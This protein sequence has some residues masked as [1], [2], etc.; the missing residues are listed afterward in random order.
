MRHSLGVVHRDLKPSNILLTK[1]DVP[2]ISDFGLAKL[3]GEQDDSASVTHL[4]TILGTPSYMA[5]EQTT[6]E[7]EEIGRAVDIYA[8][9]MILYELLAGRRPFQAGTVMEMMMQIRERRPD[10]P[11]RWQPGLPPS[12]TRSACAAWRSC[13]GTAT[14]RPESWPTPWNGS[15]RRPRVRAPGFW[16]RAWGLLPFKR[17]EGRANRQRV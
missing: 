5:P 17:T 14:R 4:G 13:P 12:L 8:L 10:P 15:W 2:K 1:D 6:G 16:D 3:V 7:I 9:G 11:S